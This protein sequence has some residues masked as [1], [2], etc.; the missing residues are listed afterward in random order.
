[1]LEAIAADLK[2]WARMPYR[3]NGNL[4]DWLLFIGILT[5]GTFLWSRIIKSILD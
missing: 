3:E 5:C 4:L 1:M 2:E